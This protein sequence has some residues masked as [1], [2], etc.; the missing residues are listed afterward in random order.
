MAGS[1]VTELQ[2]KLTTA[3][4]D[5]LP[6]LSR[7]FSAFGKDVK[8]ADINFKQF[9]QELRKHRSE[10]TKSINNTRALSNTWKELAASVDF[11]SK[12]FREATAE[13]KRLNIELN[14]MEK[15]G[16]KGIGGRLRGATKT[17]GTIAAAGV[18][19]GPEG[20]VGA[21]IGGMLGGVGGAAVGGAIGA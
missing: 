3:G 15:G 8:K 16:R 12:E 20:L 11:G 1:A 10:N 21:G 17:V 6:Q 9:A 19:G 13:A 7:A 2:I 18:F 5:K 4:V 14:K